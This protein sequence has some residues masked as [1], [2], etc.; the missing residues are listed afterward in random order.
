VNWATVRPI[1]QPL[2]PRSPDT[3]AAVIANGDQLRAFL[4]THFRELGLDIHDPATVAPAAAILA[5]LSAAGASGARK[6]LLTPEAGQAVVD[7]CRVMG[8][9][10]G[11]LLPPGVL[12]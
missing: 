9:A 6:Q 12:P 2:E 4:V 5:A 7:C 3:A 10:L 1:L 8:S 11:A